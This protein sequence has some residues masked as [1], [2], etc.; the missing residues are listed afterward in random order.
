MSLPYVQPDFESYSL[1]QLY[2]VR[3]H[4][5]AAAHPERAVVVERLIAEKEAS[6]VREPIADRPFWLPVVLAVLSLAVVVGVGLSKGPKAAL[7]AALITFVCLGADLA[8]FGYLDG[9]R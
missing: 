8:F 5:D 6:G 3:E 2:D 1:N 7:F 4:L 9:H